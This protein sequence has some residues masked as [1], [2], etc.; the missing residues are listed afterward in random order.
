MGGAWLLLTDPISQPT[1]TPYRAENEET[2]GSSDEKDKGKP[3]VWLE[4]ERL[5][6]PTSIEYLVC[7]SGL[8][9]SYGR[10]CISPPK[11]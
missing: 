7:A 2:R 8:L 9:R 3:S 4:Q 11:P 5:S 6:T 1:G 10:H